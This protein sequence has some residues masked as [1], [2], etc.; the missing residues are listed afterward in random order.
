MAFSADE[1]R[2]LRRALAENLH[3]GRP[4]EAA[5]GWA[6]D[7]QEL[8]RLADAID[9]AVREGGR[10][11]AFLLAELGRYR[12]ALPGGA[13]GYLERLEEAVA[14]GYL[15][16]AADLAALRRLSALP[17]GP[18]ERAR[19]A[20]L[21]DRC[22]A[23]AEAAVRRRLA[24][25]VPRVRV[26]GLELLI[27]GAAVSPVP[28]SSGGTIP[29]TAKQNA[30]EP[31]ETSPE[32]EAPEEQPQTPPAKKTAPAKKQQPVKPHIPTPAEL[33][34]HGVRRTG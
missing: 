5:A 9:E 23:L 34:P 3:P 16:D 28:A 2:V 29:M 27:G 21:A 1:V 19:R 14:D 31:V 8:V 20:A 15:P 22:H 25:S 32:D 17:C 26:R 10:L 12:A 24:A 33:F 7:V 30:N 13:A 4:T 11:R 6:E 18:A